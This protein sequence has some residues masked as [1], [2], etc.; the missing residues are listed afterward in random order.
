MSTAIVLCGWILLIG[1]AG[2]CPPCAGPWVRRLALGLTLTT[3]LVSDLWRTVARALQGHEASPLAG[4]ESAYL[5]LW[6][7]VLL[8]ILRRQ[9]DRR[10]L[11]SHLLGGLTAAAAF[12]LAHESAPLI[13]AGLRESW[14]NLGQTGGSILA[15]GVHMILGLAGLTL[16]RLMDPIQDRHPGR[17]PWDYPAWYAGLIAMRQALA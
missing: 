3:L 14:P 10:A 13:L 5:S 15:V 6:I 7:L 17:F 8:P 16:R 12:G 11:E 1:A 2:W 4:P 9:L